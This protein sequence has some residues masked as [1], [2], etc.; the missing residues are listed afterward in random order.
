MTSKATMISNA[1]L[2]HDHECVLNRMQMLAPKGHPMAH[3]SRSAASNSTLARAN[4][5]DS[6]QFHRSPVR[7]QLMN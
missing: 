5:F 2:H 3:V 7:S 6:A 4:T 1:A